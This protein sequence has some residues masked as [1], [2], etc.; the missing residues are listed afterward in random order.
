MDEMV[1]VLG[2]T[3]GRVELAGRLFT[4]IELEWNRL[5]WEWDSVC[6]LSRERLLLLFFFDGAILVKQRIQ[7]KV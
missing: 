1:D 2:G 3:G 6:R 7:C 5:D 4:A